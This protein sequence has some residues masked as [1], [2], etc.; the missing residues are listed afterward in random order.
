M[1]IEHY[2]LKTDPYRATTMTHPWPH[3]LGTAAAATEILQLVE[4]VKAK[5]LTLLTDSGF[6]TEV[7]HFH[8]R[9]E[10]VTKPEYPIGDRP[11]TMLY[12]CWSGD[13]PV[14]ANLDEAKN[15]VVELLASKGI[16]G[17]GVELV[18]WY[19]SFRPSMFAIQ[20]DDPAVPIYNDTKRGS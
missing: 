10:D 15:A 1:T 20:P 3:P 16:S 14:P 9:I 19:R 11:Q 13:A 6:S 5:I 2:L 7:H 8:L 12:L 4:S 17:V 18:F